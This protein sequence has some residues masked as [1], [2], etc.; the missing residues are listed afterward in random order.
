[1]VL[2][3]RKQYLAIECRSIEM[4]QI[5]NSANSVAAQPVQLFASSWIALF[6]MIRSSIAGTGHTE[7]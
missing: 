3:N 1:M 5:S 6:L 7:R 2:R 4:N